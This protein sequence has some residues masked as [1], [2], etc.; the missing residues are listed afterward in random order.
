M[1]EIRDGYLVRYGMII[2]HR[3]ILGKNMAIF[4]VTPER[5]Y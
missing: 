4:I 5:M 1:A 3:D 2:D